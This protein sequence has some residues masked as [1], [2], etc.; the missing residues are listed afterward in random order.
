VPCCSQHP[1]A[2]MQA[3]T[4]LWRF[5][6]SHWYSQLVPAKRLH[7]YHPASRARAN[8]TV[9]LMLLI[10]C[11]GVGVVFPDQ[12]N[13]SQYRSIGAC[14][15]LLLTLIVFLLS[16][17]RDHAT[18]DFQFLVACMDDLLFVHNNLIQL[19]AR[20]ARRAGMELPDPALITAQINISNKLIE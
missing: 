9:F 8:W 12:D 1:C 20:R 6:G 19:R 17:C 7:A 4:G 5:H 15:G 16:S 11:L 10:V 2:C 3:P 13:L 14:L 18:G